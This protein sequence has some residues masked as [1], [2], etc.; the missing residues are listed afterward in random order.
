MY[1]IINVP[2]DEGVAAVS[3]GI[4]AKVAS[5]RGGVP[6]QL[7][8]AVVA[9]VGEDIAKITTR[10]RRPVQTKNETKWL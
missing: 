5:A 6:K 9:D 2:R 3:A 8:L 7:G 1:H 4:I 10:S